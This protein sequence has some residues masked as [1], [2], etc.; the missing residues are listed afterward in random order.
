[1]QTQPLPTYL[2]LHRSDPKIVFIADDIADLDPD[3]FKTFKVNPLLISSISRLPGNL[4]SQLVEYKEEMYI[5]S[6]C[7]RTWRQVSH[8][9]FHFHFSLNRR[10][11]LNV[12]LV[13]VV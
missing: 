8:R 12:K 4:G 7:G 1:M 10:P 3:L 6:D 11:V 13:Y 2:V 5:T 9:T